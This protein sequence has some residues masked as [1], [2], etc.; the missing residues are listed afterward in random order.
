[1]ANWFRL[2]FRELVVWAYLQ[3]SRRPGLPDRDFASW[4]DEILLDL[5]LRTRCTL[6]IAVASGAH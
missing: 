4:G 1:M 5:N 3:T 6:D 2:A